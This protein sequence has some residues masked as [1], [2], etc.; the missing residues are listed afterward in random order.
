LFE[1]NL[2]ALL[3]KIAIDS[4]LLGKR[5]LQEVT[6]QQGRAGFSA[7]QREAS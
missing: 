6:E 2:L 3:G 7:D 5:V 1:K 4:P